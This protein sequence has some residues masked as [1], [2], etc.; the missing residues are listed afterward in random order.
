ME[1]NFFIMID[2][3]KF[4]NKKCKK[5][6]V[7]FLLLW[8]IVMSSYNIF[9]QRDN[10]KGQRNPSN[11]QYEDC[12]CDFKVN[13]PIFHGLN[14]GEISDNDEESKGA[15]T[16]AN[17]NGDNGCT[18]IDL[19]KLI[20]E[21]KGKKASNCDVELIPDGNVS[22]WNNSDR[23]G[24]ITNL[25]F[26]SDDLPKTIWIEALDVSTQVKDIKIEAKVGNT[27]YDKVSATAI[28]C[29]FVNKYNDGSTPLPSDDPLNSV[30]PGYSDNDGD[31]YGLG[32][33]NQGAQGDPAYGGRILIEF[34]LI[35]NGIK[36]IWP[37][38]FDVTRRINKSRD[39]LISGQNT[40]T[41]IESKS[42]PSNPDLPND[43]AISNDDED[44][45]PNQL[46]GFDGPSEPVNPGLDVGQNSYGYIKS[47]HN[48]E[49]YVRMSFE[50]IQGNG[51][52]LYG[53]RCSDKVPWV[54]NRCLKIWSDNTTD[55]YAPPNQRYKVI[56]GAVTHSMPTRVFGI[57][58]G[59]IEIT[60]LSNATS[61]GYTI[62]F[63]DNNIAELYNATSQVSMSNKINGKW[64]LEEINKIK[65]VVTDDLVNPYNAVDRLYFSV[66]NSASIFN[67][68]KIE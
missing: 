53:S 11:F 22:F 3:F 32:Y 4:K 60:F 55:P 20:I 44:N 5:L 14:G 9:A 7:T 28:W 30:I 61:D 18:E 25:I 37:L 62:L 13:L 67:D 56:E 10:D 40:F 27:I 46:F 19:I 38:Y 57:G 52:Q 2:G 8:L 24:A 1:I 51:N 26:N 6:K 35:P 33:F 49:E 29:N 17:K 54:H 23:T 50:P 43:D 45:I 41:N 63:K 65:V 16:V 66:L 15:V 42:F 68:I 34:Q 58:K 12:G 59:K 64:M 21:P 31:Y 47:D 39:G 36:D 48:F